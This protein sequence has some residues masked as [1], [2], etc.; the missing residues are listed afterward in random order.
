MFRPFSE[1]F[2]GGGRFFANFWSRAGDFLPNFG[3]GR[4]FSCH[5]LVSGGGEAD[6]FLGGPLETKTEVP[7]AIG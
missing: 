3:L 1:F 5:F 6:F 2:G 7:S 4:R